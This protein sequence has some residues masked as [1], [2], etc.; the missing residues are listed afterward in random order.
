MGKDNFSST[1]Q[2]LYYFTCI[3]KLDSL[4]EMDMDIRITC[5]ACAHLR[6]FKLP[7]E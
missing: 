7:D 2:S 6:M 4:E 1:P 5:P 3:V